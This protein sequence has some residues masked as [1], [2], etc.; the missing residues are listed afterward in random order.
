MNRNRMLIGAG[1]AVVLALF[2]SMFVYKEFKTASSVVAPVPTGRMVVAAQPLAL[3][4][5]LD[6]S[7]LKTIPWPGNEHVDGMFADMK[8]CANRALLTNVAENEPILEAKLAPTQAGAGLPATIPEGMRALSVAVNDVV[9]VAGFVIPGTMVD[10]LVTG[11]GGGAARENVTRTIL[12]NVRVLAAGQKIQ[13]DRDGK[14]QTVPV[15]TLL[16]TPEDAVKLTMASTEG[17]IQ[18]A[19]RNTIDTKTVAPAAVLQ[20]TLFAGAP[21]PAPAHHAGPRKAGPPPVYIYT[22]EVINGA[23]RETKSFPNQ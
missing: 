22:V 17:K 5:R 13:Q 23:K 11:M 6:A 15:V 4:T 21:A 18:L 16:V 20:E 1:I 8:D 2:L 10:V 3:G 9:G 14:P 7:N 19:L 12:E